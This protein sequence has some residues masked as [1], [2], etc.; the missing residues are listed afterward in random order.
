MS[1]TKQEADAASTKVQAMARRMFARD[2]AYAM[3][4]EKWEKIFDPVR[5]RY[6]Y[7]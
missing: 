6:Y 7:Y 5:A 4:A 3:V 2:V 1:L